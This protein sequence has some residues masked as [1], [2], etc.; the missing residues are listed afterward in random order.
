MIP[1][2]TTFQ[3]A[4]TKPRRYIIFAL[5][6]PRKVTRAETMQRRTS[7]TTITLHANKSHDD[8][9]TSALTESTFGIHQRSKWPIGLASVWEYPKQ[10]PVNGR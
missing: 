2:K 4:A 1:R 7:K 3:R 6:E 10:S 9:A 8:R 5:R